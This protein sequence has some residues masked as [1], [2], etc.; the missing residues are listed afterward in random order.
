MPVRPLSEIMDGCA[1]PCHG[2][3]DADVLRLRFREAI[4]AGYSQRAIAAALG[5]SHVTVGRVLKFPVGS[6]GPSGQER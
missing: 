6:G 3:T 2:A 5:T 4:A 1:W